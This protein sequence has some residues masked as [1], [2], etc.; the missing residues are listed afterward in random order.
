MSDQDFETIT[1]RV[2]TKRAAELRKLLQIFDQGGK[3]E[4][5][6]HGLAMVVLIDEHGGQSIAS[7]D[8]TGNDAA[9]HSL[10]M[11]RLTIA[12]AAG[13]LTL[14]KVLRSRALD[15]FNEDVAGSLD[16]DVDVLVQQ[17][18]WKSHKIGRGESY[19]EALD[20]HQQPDTEGGAP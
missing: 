2:P 16:R 6:A 10:I 17:C 1:V 3:S 5:A 20:N 19:G 18:D 8:W 9:C 14:R 7:M 4:D 13:I 11:G 15:H 12:V